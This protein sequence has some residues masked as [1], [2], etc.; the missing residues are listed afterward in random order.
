MQ[1]SDQSRACIWG[2]YIPYYTV[3]YT[4]RWEIGRCFSPFLHFITFLSQLYSI[5]PSH[6]LI[7]EDDGE[8]QRSVEQHLSCSASILS[9][10][11]W[12]KTGS[13]CIGYKRGTFSCFW[14]YL[15]PP[16][17]E[18]L[19]LSLRFKVLISSQDGYK[20]W[21]WSQ[22]LFQLYQQDGGDVGHHLKGSIL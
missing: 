9:C 16:I 20:L 6:F 19:S 18:T 3:L 4:E 2:K 13:H 12:F 8:G 17:A 5:P 21:A 14:T 1:G 11:S 10:Q 22:V 15:H 7:L